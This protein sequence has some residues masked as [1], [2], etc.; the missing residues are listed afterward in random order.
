MGRREGAARDWTT[1]RA[2]RIPD[3]VW[4]AAKAEAERRGETVSAAILRF[5]RRYGSR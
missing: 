1:P 5:L 4:D 2:V 3:D